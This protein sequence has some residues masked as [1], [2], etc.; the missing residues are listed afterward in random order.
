MRHCRETVVASGSCGTR[1][2]A[3]IPAARFDL[4]C[5]SICC[6]RE[7]ALLADGGG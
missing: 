7:H 2:R 1:S 6:R 4:L 5:H 3:G